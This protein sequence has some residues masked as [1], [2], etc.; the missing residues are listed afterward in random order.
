MFTRYPFSITNHPNLPF[1]VVVN[2]ASGPGATNSQPDANYQACIP[3]LRPAANP[4]VK[5]LGYV[6]TGF[7]SRA[8]SAVQADITTYSQ[9]GAAYKP[10]GIFFD[11]VAANSGNEALYSGYSSFAKGKISGAAVSSILS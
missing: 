4:N 7:G 3:Q 11:E 8:Q 9:W 6:P 2:P 10:S 5:V 1:W